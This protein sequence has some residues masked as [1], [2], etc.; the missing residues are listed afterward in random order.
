MS[1]KIT[2]SGSLKSLILK[3]NVIKCIV[4]EEKVSMSD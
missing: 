3:V 4:V 2:V 1:N